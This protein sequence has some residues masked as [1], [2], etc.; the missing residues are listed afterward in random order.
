MLW[1]KSE[2]LLWF[3]FCPSDWSRPRQKKGGQKNPG[4]IG[5]LTPRP[6]SFKESAAIMT[7]N[8]IAVIPLEVIQDRR[9]TLEQTRVLIALAL[10][11]HASD[12]G[13]MAKSPCR[14]FVAAGCGSPKARGAKPHTEKFA[15]FS[16]PATSFGGSDGMAKAMPVTLRVPRSSTPIRAA[17]LRGSGT[18]VVHQAQPEQT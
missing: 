12:D 13:L 4:I 9:L 6:G 14:K 8:Q 16:I 11:N 15:A 5:A 17:A 7:E 10:A 18:A 3:L 1:R 2:R